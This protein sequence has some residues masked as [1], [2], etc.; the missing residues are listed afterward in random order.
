MAPRRDPT[1]G[2][3]YSPSSGNEGMRIKWGENGKMRQMR[4]K[5]RGNEL[6][7]RTHHETTLEH[8][9]SMKMHEPFINELRSSDIS[10]DGRLKGT[11]PLDKCPL[12][13][14]LDNATMRC[15]RWSVAR[16]EYAP[17]S[18]EPM[19]VKHHPAFSLQMF[20]NGRMLL[21]SKIVN[22]Y[23]LQTWVAANVASV[24]L[25]NASLKSSSNW[26]STEPNVL[27]RFKLI[28]ALGTQT[29]D[30][31]SDSH[32]FKSG[33]TTLW[34]R[35]LLPTPMHTAFQVL[36][37]KWIIYICGYS[38]ALVT[39]KRGFEYQFFPHPPWFVLESSQKVHQSEIFYG[40]VVASEGLRI[41][42]FEHARRSGST[43][44][45]LTNHC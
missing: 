33:T 25:E 18:N 22:C 43:T 27:L 6:L 12:M 14:G 13:R 35:G 45:S 29:N 5:N 32:R 34:S 17:T 10:Y 37:T 8:A 24:P 42:K 28:L 2:L 41:E 44:F 1:C 38:G 40:L 7:V 15:V 39:T 26:F 31:S 30:C 16:Y 21:E 19:S 20:E 23:Y 3:F 9:H 36:Q 4:R 11:R